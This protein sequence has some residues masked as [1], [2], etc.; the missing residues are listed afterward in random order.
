[1]HVYIFDVVKYQ[2]KNTKRRNAVKPS[3]KPPVYRDHLPI[4]SPFADL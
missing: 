2:P 1:M 3:L 4:R